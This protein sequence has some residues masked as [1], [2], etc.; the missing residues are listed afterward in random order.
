MSTTWFSRVVL[1]WYREHKRPLPWRASRDPYRIWL[2]EV[3]L[4]QTRV[5]QGTAYWHRFVERYPRVRDLA[6]RIVTQQNGEI[7]DFQRAATRLGVPL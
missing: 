1:P 4:Q 6:T 7:A 5:D 2:S 3:I